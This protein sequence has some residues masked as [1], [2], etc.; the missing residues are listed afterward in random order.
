[1]DVTFSF[2]KW[3]HD[4]SDMRKMPAENTGVRMFVCVWGGILYNKNKKY[5]LCQVIYIW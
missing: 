5:T 1:M 2:S 3:R 4:A